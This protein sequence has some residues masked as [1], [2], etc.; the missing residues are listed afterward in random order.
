V[1]VHPEPCSP[2][3]FG[4]GVCALWFKGLG[5]RVQVSGYRVQGLGVRVQRVEQQVHLREP[6]PLSL[7]G[8]AFRIYGLG[9]GFRV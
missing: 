2:N 1:P 8:V 4:L 6:A 3:A 9:L 5:F 7:K